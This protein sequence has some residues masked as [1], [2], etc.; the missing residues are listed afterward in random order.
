MKLPRTQEAVKA[1]LKARPWES[2]L[3]HQ[4]YKARVKKETEISPDTTA[5]KV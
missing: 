5:V 1:L 3:I 2:M 4:I